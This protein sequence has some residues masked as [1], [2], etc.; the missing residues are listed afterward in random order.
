MINI[1]GGG[2]AESQYFLPRTNKKGLSPS[3][4]LPCIKSYA[5]FT[6]AGLSIPN[7]RAC[8][9]GTEEKLKSE[10]GKPRED[11]ER[12]GRH[13]AR[14]GRQTA[15]LPPRSPHE[16]GGDQNP[17][18]AGF[19]NPARRQRGDRSVISHAQPGRNPKKQAPASVTGACFTRRGFSECAARA[20][21]IKTMRPAYERPPTETL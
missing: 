1:L 2:G 19:G 9:G 6:L 10:T 21:F 12:A 14:G 4:P 17:I 5:V 7:A 13:A 16:V 3:F 18:P 15:Q 20:Y 11:P 8:G